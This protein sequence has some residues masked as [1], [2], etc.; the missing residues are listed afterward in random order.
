MRLIF[1]TSKYSQ[2]PYLRAYYD[3][4]D[5]EEDDDY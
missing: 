1:N 4:D 3:G 2:T 5:E